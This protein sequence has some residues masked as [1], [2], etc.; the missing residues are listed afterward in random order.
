MNHTTALPYIKIGNL[1][2][3]PVLPERL[4][5]ALMVRRAIQKLNLGRR[6]TVVISRPSSVKENYLEAVK[7]LPLSTLLYI[8]DP[9]DAASDHPVDEPEEGEM[10]KKELVTIT[11]CDGLAE[12]AL[13]ALECNIE[14]HFIDLDI[15]PLMQAQRSPCGQEPLGIDDWLCLNIG[16][17]AFVDLFHDHPAL[18]L[19]RILPVD[20]WRERHM[21]GQL[22]RLHPR[23]ERVLFVCYV[24]NVQGILQALKSPLTILDAPEFRGK[25]TS[26]EPKTS[27]LL[28]FLDDY[29]KVVERY[30]MCRTSPEAVKKFDK[31]SIVL[32][33]LIECAA[34]SETRNWPIRH[35][36]AFKQML[37]GVLRE[38]GQ[39]STP[40]NQCLNLVLSCYDRDFAEALR[41]RLLTFTAGNVPEKEILYTFPMAHGDGQ[42][43]TNGASQYSNPLDP[44]KTQAANDQ[45]PGI[46]S[47]RDSIF[48]GSPPLVS[49]KDQRIFVR[50]CNN[51]AQAF[52]K[53]VESEEDF[54]NPELAWPAWIMHHNEMRKRIMRIAASKAIT[55]S[56]E[57][58]R[59]GLERGLDLRRIIRASYK[60]DPSLY[61]KRRRKNS[62]FNSAP[63]GI[64]PILWFFN[65]TND[66]WY[67][68]QMVRTWNAEE[69]NADRWTFKYL[70]GQEWGQTKILRWRFDKR[71]I[72][73]R[74]LEFMVSFTERE[75]TPTEIEKRYKDTAVQFPTQDLTTNSRNVFD[76][77]RKIVDSATSHIF[78]IV[79]AHEQIPNT[80]ANYVGQ[81]RKN[82]VIL[83][84]SD[85]GIQDIEKLSHSISVDI[86]KKPK[87]KQNIQWAVKR[88]QPLVD[89]LWR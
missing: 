45:E 15:S 87:T 19:R 2:V 3:T 49:G 84:H 85:V 33:E 46:F 35:H 5:G 27:L 25:V 53:G 24:E 32:E 52:K 71:K 69:D 6:D 39:A 40:L 12:A 1:F 62:T 10:I 11:P 17:E 55:T 74:Q 30:W 58:Y 56:S 20:D 21:A 57:R 80:L 31:M 8:A 61:V 26:V 79:P 88:Y 47:A 18:R 82:M 65:S 9:R 36:Q 38:S 48:D 72:K 37:A 43:T 7:K 77:F 50:S 63:Q 51:N 73:L 60:G 78:C 68:K 23:Y 34:S 44:L 13:S 28:Q 67:S 89:F 59:G 76:I 86:E 4:S 42:A 64:T 70:V 81:S 41:K 14:P 75:L 83:K 66:S 16:A 54:F 22:Q 29:P